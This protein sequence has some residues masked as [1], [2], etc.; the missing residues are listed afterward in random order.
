ML[1]RIDYC[2]R[3]LIFVS[4]CN[5]FEIASQPEWT[6]CLHFPHKSTHFLIILVHLMYFTYY[7][8]T[9]IPLFFNTL[10]KNDSK[11]DTRVYVRM[12]TYICTHGRRT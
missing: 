9:E 12:C 7:T 11:V 3:K 1:E 6:I 2:V 8:C 10:P 4:C 5:S